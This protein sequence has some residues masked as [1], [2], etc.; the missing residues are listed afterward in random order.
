MQYDGTRHNVGFAVVD[1][2]AGIWRMPLNK[3]KFSARFADGCCD[4]QKVALLKPQTF[5]NKSGQAVWA[6]VKF[7][8]IEPEDLLVIGDDMAL[9]LGQLRLRTNGS[10]GGHNG[11][12]NIIDRTGCRDF[13]RLRLGIGDPV[14][15]SEAFVLSKFKPGELDTVERML[16]DAADAVECW[17]KS[18]PGETMNRFNRKVKRN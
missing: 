11:L 15:P 18:G 5:M 2:L 7:F 10:G 14:G 13:C 16:F 4:D 1:R 12:Q 8:K 3:E 6:A 17:L 9:P